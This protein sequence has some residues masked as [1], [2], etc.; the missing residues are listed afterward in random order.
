MKFVPEW[1]AVIKTQNYSTTHIVHGEVQNPFHN[2][3][4]RPKAGYSSLKI[5]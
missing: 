3:G 2:S 1:R 5:A 4:D